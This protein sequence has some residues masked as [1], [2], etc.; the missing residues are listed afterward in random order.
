M[1]VLFLLKKKSSYGGDG[2]SILESGLLNSARMTMQALEDELGIDGELEIVVDG[3]SIDREIHRFKPNVVILEAVWVT[4]T[5]LKEL[6]RLHPKVVFIIR[7]HSEVPYLA[8]EGVSIDWILEYAGIDR[9][10]TSFNSRRTRDDFNDIFDKEFYYLPN[11]YEDIK[12]PHKVT[13][14]SRRDGGIP[15]LINIGC[16]GAIRPMKNHLQ[17]AVAALSLAEKYGSLLY[18]HVNAPRVEQ[19]GAAVL[20]NLRS[21]FDETKHV[22]VEHPW[23]DREDFLYLIED[24]DCGMQVSFNE[25]FNI[26]TADFVKVG[27]P[28]VV[29]SSISWMPEAVKVSTEVTKDMVQGLEYVL[30]HPRNIVRQSRKALNEYNEKATT[31]WRKFLF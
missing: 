27:R 5:K 25:S 30:N 31:V 14:Y 13:E 16:F 22:L 6:V 18:F 10:Y 19:G 2:Y 21:L 3:N 28:I 29:S 9:V 8:Q 20:K 15:K 17:Q 12:S 23:L 1:K 24:M 7:I 11:I 26:V 4:P